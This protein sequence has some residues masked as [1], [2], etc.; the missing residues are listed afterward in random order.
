MAWAVRFEA[1]DSTVDRMNENTARSLISL[2]KTVRHI[3]FG[4]STRCNIRCAHCVAA[5]GISP[6]TQMELKQ[7]EAIIDEMA[8]SHVTGISF[9]AGEPFLFVDEI[10]QLIRRCR[11]YGIYTRM[12][13]NAFWARTGPQADAVV[14]D[15]LEKGLSQL[16]ISFSRWHR[17]SIPD[18][19]ILHAASACKKLGLD[20][21][22]SFVTDFS[23][24]DD[25]IEDFFRN[26]RL[27]YFPEPLIYSGRAGGFDRPDIHNDYRPNRCSMNPYLSPELDMFACCDAGASFTQTG[28][29]H[30]G[31][32]R[33]VTIDGMFRKKETNALYNLIRIMG[34]SAMA[35]YLGFPAS[36]IVRYQKC[37]LCGEMFNSPENLR[38]LQ[39]A[40]TSDL[41]EWKR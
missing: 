2:M 38:R 5:D 1:G 26:H 39:E 31:N 20:Y 35:S 14:G 9:T 17:K 27:K 6:A 23:T 16:R 19:N 37:E 24:R 25:A 10:G 22:I 8:Q 33:D 3:A 11:G 34:L 40:V 29:F 4:Y 30:L 32:R 41:A 15:L 36:R 28:F 21:F 7:A 12:V 13:T 18:H